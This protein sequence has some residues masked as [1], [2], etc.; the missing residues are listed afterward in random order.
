MESGIN[1]LLKSFS[2]KMLYFEVRRF[3]LLR[4]FKG[5]ELQLGL[6]SKLV[7]AEIGYKTYIAHN[8]QFLNSSL[9]DYSYINYD[10]LVQFTTIG[11]FCSIGPGV[12]IVLGSH[13]MHMVSTHPA[14][15]SSGI[16]VK[17]FTDRRLYHDEFKRVTIGNDVWIGEDALIPGGIKIGD[18]A[19]IAARAVVTKDVE[20]YSFVAGVPAKHVKYRFSKEIINQL[21]KIKWWDK[22]EKWFKENYLSFQDPEKFVSTFSDEEV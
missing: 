3:R 11:K 8:T 10:A 15:Y 12:K 20:P 7:N 6:G 21:V 16:M 18:G 4:K 2:L 5:K 13:P 17:S 14:F 22:N 19:I 1:R 9:G